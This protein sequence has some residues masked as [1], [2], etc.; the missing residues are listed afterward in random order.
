M[1]ITEYLNIID[2]ISDKLVFNLEYYNT[3]EPFKIGCSTLNE[4]IKLIELKRTI[5][6]IYLI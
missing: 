4:L 5:L 3:F 1:N 6:S 2:S